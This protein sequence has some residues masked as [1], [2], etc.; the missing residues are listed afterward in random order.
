M[1][2]NEIITYDVACYSERD[3]PA[4]HWSLTVDGVTVSHLWVDIPTGE[5]CQVETG[6]GHQRQGYASRLYRAAAA[7]MSVYH[8]PQAHRTPEGRRFADSVGGPSLPCHHGCCRDDG[9]DW[10]D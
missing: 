7:Q 3:E 5:I 4:H 1:D 2:A 10:D 6:P 8:A 9:A